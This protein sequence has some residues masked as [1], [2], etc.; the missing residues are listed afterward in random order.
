M[1]RIQELE[2]ELKELKKDRLYCRFYSPGSF[3]SE[4]TRRAVDSMDLPEACSIASEVNE[5]HGARPFGFRF[6]DGNGDSLSGMH[7]IEGEVLTYDEIEDKPVNR[8]LRSNIKSN[9]GGVIV[10]TRRGFRHTAEFKPTDLVVSSA[11]V[12]LRSGSE[13]KLVAYRASFRGRP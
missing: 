11:G 7:Y 3:F 6:E 10:I 4:T 8:I 12:V 2:Q 13:E 5:R 1:S 9:M